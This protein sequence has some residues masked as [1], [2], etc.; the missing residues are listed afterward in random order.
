MSIYRL[1]KRRYQDSIRRFV[2]ETI[3]KKESI[4][5]STR[6]TSPLFNCHA[7]HYE[8]RCRTDGDDLEEAAALVVQSRLRVARNTMFKLQRLA[9][10]AMGL[11]EFRDLL[12][13]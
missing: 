6:I 2:I 3:I 8:S 5:I 1:G 9:E 13:L 12:F 4:T 11:P 10:K 7:V